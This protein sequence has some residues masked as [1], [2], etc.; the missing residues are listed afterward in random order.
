[1]STQPQTTTKLSKAK[2]QPT[3]ADAVIMQWHQTVQ[4]MYGVSD[5][6]LDEMTAGYNSIYSVFFGVFVGGA[7]TLWVTYRTTSIEPDKSYFLALAFSCL[8]LSIFFGIA[9]IRNYYRAFKKKKKLY[10]EAV[11]IKWP[12]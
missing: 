9:F 10:E 12:Q 4:K 1:M 2:S 11:P 3:L 7:I 8:G 5:S 6:A